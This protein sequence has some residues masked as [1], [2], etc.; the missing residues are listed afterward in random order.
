MSFVERFIIIIVSLFR[1]VHYWRFNC[2]TFIIVG[3]VA[4]LN[5]KYYNYYYSATKLRHNVWGLGNMCSIVSPIAIN[6]SNS[7]AVS[8]K[9]VSTYEWCM[10]LRLQAND[11][12]L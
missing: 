3:I 7:G 11:I 8:S 6:V 10:G 4:H 2:I 9:T 12:L 1:R 5:Q